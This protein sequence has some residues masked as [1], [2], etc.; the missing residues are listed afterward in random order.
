MQPSQEKI[1]FIKSQFPDRALYVVD[2]VAVDKETN[3]ETVL[4]VIMTGPTRE[5]HRF[6]TVKMMAA[7]DIKD[8]AEKLWA[9]RSAVENAALAQIRWPERDEVKKAFDARP[10]MVDDFAG[11]LR[12]FAGYNVELRSKKL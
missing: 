12:E 11:K 7:N 1:E 4:T 10:E 9:V 6:Y 8:A 5:E 2:A 3:E